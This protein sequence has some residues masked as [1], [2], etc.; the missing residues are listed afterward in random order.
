MDLIL[1]FCAFR[2]SLWI[3]VSFT[4]RSSTNFSLF[5]PNLSLFTISVLYF[6]GRMSNFSKLYYCNCVTFMNST[7]LQKVFHIASYF[8]RWRISEVFPAHKLQNEFLIEKIRA[9][10]SFENGIFGICRDICT[11]IIGMIRAKL[12]NDP[13]VNYANTRDLLILSLASSYHFHSSVFHVR[14]RNLRNFN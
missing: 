5:T 12:L 9:Q 8:L 4:K 3:T 13:K 2:L 6:E 1:L 11:K 10:V 7:R 14:F